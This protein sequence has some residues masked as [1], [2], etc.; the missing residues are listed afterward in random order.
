MRFIITFIFIALWSLSSSGQIVNIESRRIQSDTTGWL[1][2][3]KAGFLLQKNAVK[4]ININA[5]ANVEYK[6]PRSLYLFLVNYSLLK[7][8]G[9]S[10]ANN[11][12]Y[13][14]RYN[15]KINSLLRWE[16][17]TQLQQNSVTGIKV[18]WLTGTGPRF[19]LSGSKK[20]LLY[21]G[22]AAM[23]ELEREQTNPVIIHR[24]LR[25]SN[26]VSI[27]YKLVESAEIIG[28]L[29][30]QPLFRNINDARLLNEVSLKFQLMKNL[31]FATNWYYL[32]DSRP[33]AS[34]PK[35]NY[36]ISNG[37]EYTF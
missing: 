1:G 36:S 31:S 18:R 2:N 12:F 27:T 37:I 9:Q 16:A 6:S 13:H 11:L 29:F 20:V 32:F 4:V 24:D 28:T 26:Y 10:L 15:Y 8:N 17:F 5:G 22:T 23:Y 21:A 7:G 25:S 19:K 30:F 34:T 3:A 33:A 14:L 35:L